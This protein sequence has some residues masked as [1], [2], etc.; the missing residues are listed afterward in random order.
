METKSR[1]RHSHEME[2]IND[3]NKV[4]EIKDDNNVLVGV[5][6]VDENNW[7]HCGD[8]LLPR[9]MASY[10]GSQCAITET[11]ENIK[12][13][14]KDKYPLFCDCPATINV[15]LSGVVEQDE[16]GN[17]HLGLYKFPRER[18]S[19]SLVGKKIVVCK[20]HPNPQKDSKFYGV[21][22]HYHLYKSGKKKKRKNLKE[23]YY[24]LDTNVF[25][26][27]PDIL[28]KIGRDYGIIIVNHVI[29]ELDGLKKSDDKEISSAA[30]HAS[31]KIL[32]VMGYDEVELVNTKYPY[33]P[34]EQPYT[35]DQKILSAA[36]LKKF[37]G[38]RVIVV[39]SDKNMLILAKMHGIE[40]VTLNSYL[41]GD[42]PDAPRKKKVSW[43]G[44][45]KWISVI[46][47]SFLAG[48]M[49]R[50]EFDKN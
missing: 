6:E 25:I 45:L 2:T 1:E 27:C 23:I 15:S 8:V 9:T 34:F 22:I 35:M 43:K 44:I 13:E 11:V 48:W 5:I 3:N 39:S 42:Y 24:L 28:D 32:N 29:T 19:P 4:S 38:E 50:K 31:T 14:V 40:A 41:E 26:D 21:V 20:I 33:A 10:K 46:C 18:T 36:F 17:I 49:T 30:R 12:E 7:V 47:T 16:N 37:V